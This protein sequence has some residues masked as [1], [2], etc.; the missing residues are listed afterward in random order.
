MRKSGA[1]LLFL[2]AIFAGSALHAVQNENRIYGVI[3]TVDGEEFEGLIRWDKNEVRWLDVLDGSKKIPRERLREVRRKLRDRRDERDRDEGIFDFIFRR[4]HRMPTFSGLSL[5]GIRFG[6]IQEMEPSGSN[7]AILTLKSGEQVEFRNGSTD[8]GT[9]IRG[10]IIEDVE[11]GEVDLDW[12][13]IEVVR[14]MPAR[15]TQ[16][17]MFGPTLYGT[18]TTR[19]GDRF[20][21]PLCWDMD[22]VFASDILDGKERGRRRKIKFANIKS[23]ARYSSRAAQV[24]LKSG[25]ELVLGGTN[26]VNSGNRGIIVSDPGFG[27]VKVGWRDFKIVEFTDDESKTSYD[28]FDGG[29]RLN[30]TVYTEDGEAYTGRIRWDNDEEYSWELLDGHAG[31]LQ[32]DIEFG[33]INAI[34][35][36]SSRSVQVTVLDGRQFELSGSN[37]VSRGNRGIFIETGEG[38]LVIVEWD[39][40]KRVE[41]K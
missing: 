38:D 29:R 2:A 5:S 14:L 16:E 22:E 39:E 20:T 41:F 10:I 36:E 3:V 8:I 28:T 21:G 33:K 1:L 31:K 35:K 24:M 17:S 6:H 18:L 26:D 4:R 23:I 7:R 12:D 40:F 25:E 9:D 32:F 37:D 19:R 15:Q 13:D 27:Q 11:E 30:G 34:E